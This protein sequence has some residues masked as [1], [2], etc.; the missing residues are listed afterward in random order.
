MN[1]N[2]SEYITDTIV[3][4]RHYAFRKVLPGYPLDEGE[5]VYRVP[6]GT[7]FDPA[8]SSGSRNT[9]SPRAAESAAEGVKPEVAATYDYYIED[10]E[11]TK[12]LRERLILAG[13]DIFRYE[14][15]QYRP[16]RYLEPHEI[17][18]T[19]NDVVFVQGS[20]SINERL[21]NRH[22][23]RREIQQ[24]PEEEKLERTVKELV[25]IIKDLSR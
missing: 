7:P 21:T 10:L 6:A 23:V 1:P 14:G 11:A 12:L 24:A 25:T 5:A 3:E 18:V 22:Y 4:V 9:G 16:A 8:K 13:E 15:V 20:P 19:H 2:K 17:V